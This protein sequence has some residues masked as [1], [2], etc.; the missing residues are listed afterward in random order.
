M[1]AGWER[2]ENKHLVYCPNC[3]SARESPSAR[4]FPFR[5]LDV[6]TL[7]ECIGCGKQLLG[8]EAIVNRSFSRNLR[9]TAAKEGWKYITL[10]QGVTY[11]DYCC[12]CVPTPRLQEREKLIRLVWSKPTRI[13][14]WDMGVS[15]KALEKRC[16]RLRVP[17]PP[18][19]FWAKWHAGHTEECRALLPEEVK[20][21]LGQE[22]LD[23]I[24]SLDQ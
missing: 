8:T 24:Y 19:G 4:R 23:K 7:I 11:N 3:R 9:A 21:I 12:S 14:A 2:D 6:I 18:P 10:D 5:P 15:D 1:K 17:K 20:K 13:A 22:A 16:K